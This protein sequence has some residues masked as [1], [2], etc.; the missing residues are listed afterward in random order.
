MRRRGLHFLLPVPITP[1]L[2]LPY[3]WMVPGNFAISIEKC[4]TVL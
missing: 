2:V 1:W 3:S 4:Y